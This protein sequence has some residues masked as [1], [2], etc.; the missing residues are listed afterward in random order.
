MDRQAKLEYYRRKYQ[1]N[2]VNDPTFRQRMTDKSLARYYKLKAARTETPKLGRPKKVK[3]EVEPII[4]K[5]NGRP[6]KYSP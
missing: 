4:K 2:L 5:P 6:R 3:P 1:E